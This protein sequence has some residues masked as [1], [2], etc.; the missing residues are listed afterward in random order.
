MAPR[1]GKAK[2]GAQTVKDYLLIFEQEMKRKAKMYETS[3]KLWE[4]RLKRAQQD[5]A[6]HRKEILKKTTEV[7]QVK[8]ALFL[9]E[10]C[11]IG[12]TGFW[13]K[14]LKDKD[15]KIKAMGE[16]LKK[17]EETAA[18]RKLE[19][20]NARKRDLKKFEEQILMKKAT[21]ARIQKKVINLRKQMQVSKAEYRENIRKTEKKYSVLLNESKEKEWNFIC[22]ES[23]MNQLKAEQ[24]K[25]I[26]GL[27]S[28]LIKINKEKTWLIRNL[29][30]ALIDLD[31]LNQLVNSLSKDKLSLAVDKKTLTSTL[32]NNIC[33]MESQKQMLDEVTAEAAS[34]E[35]ALKQLKE[36]T[37]ENEKRN[38]VTIQ[39]CQVELDK[40][41]KII[42]MREKEICQVKQ[43]AKTIVEKRREMEV[44][45]HE[46]L[47]NVRQE[48]FDERKRHAR[49]AY[50]DYYQKCRDRAEGKGK[51]PLI[52]TFD[53]SP[54]STKSVY[55]DMKATGNWPHYPDKEVHMSDLTWEQKEK[56]L[57]LLFA[58]M[59]GN[60][61]CAS[62][63]STM[64]VD[65]HFRSAGWLHPRG[66]QEG[67]FV[68]VL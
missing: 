25:N 14:E 58:K 20:E 8:S 55:S 44:F 35:Q 42:A 46:A 52:R 43:L 57:T 2:K 54:N 65:C 59:N 41:Q 32:R 38:Q 56:V 21:E 50:Q 16:K 40:L 34:L 12:V 24:D 19:L 48:I 36:E 18:K 47:D 37:T 62:K 31:E 53:Q 60:A 28:E 66:L 15:E 3:T 33:E 7:E 4:I 23:E 30:S 26:V 61:E 27:E 11:G 13:L 22:R 45:F 10:K 6:Y 5:L 29:K 68:K 1:K 51:F 17:Q 67:G 63:S 39:A 49:E 64:R 9:E